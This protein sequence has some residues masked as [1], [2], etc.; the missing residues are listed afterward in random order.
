MRVLCVLLLVVSCNKQEEQEVRR[1]IT[2]QE[3]VS[4]QEGAEARRAKLTEQWPSWLKRPTGCPADVMPVEFKEHEV[5]LTS[6]Q[7][8]KIYECLQ[9]CEAF[10][11]TACYSAAV[12]MESPERAVDA[13]A[14]ALFARACTHGSASACTNWTAGL[15]IADNP[16]SDPNTPSYSSCQK[17]SLEIACLR[18]LDPWG[19]T[20]FAHALAVGGPTA[21]DKEKIKRAAVI[22]CR[23]GDEDP[24]CLRGREVVLR[25]SQ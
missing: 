2:D 5:S 7:G 14:P 19:C 3:L 20:M 15:V 10:D 18:G 9:K 24:A 4:Y 12:V 16:S 1:N 25:S 6:C 13:V 11:L 22:A 21:A 17:R 23:F 8:E